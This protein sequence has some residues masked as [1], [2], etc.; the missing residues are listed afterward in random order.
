M[1]ET[2]MVIPD[3]VFERLDVAWR[4]D[5]GERAMFRDGKI[6]IAEIRPVKD[7]EV[8]FIFARDEGQNV[9][10]RARGNLRID[11]VHSLMITLS[12]WNGVFGARTL[13]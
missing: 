10:N 6:L 9:A 2:A 1:F 3:N 12:L 11:E 7:V 13:Q 5:F 4:L 8:I